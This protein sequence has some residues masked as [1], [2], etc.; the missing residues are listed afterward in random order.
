MASAGVCLGGLPARI[1]GCL[2]ICIDLD[3][4]SRSRPC[5]E[6][7]RTL[8]LNDDNMNDDNESR[9]LSKVLHAFME[10]KNTSPEAE[11]AQVEKCSL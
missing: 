7:K 8:L 9:V 5:L 6:Q 2:A 11:Y 1:N 3:I 10:S 4:E